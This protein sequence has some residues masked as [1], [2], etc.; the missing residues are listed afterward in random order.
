MDVLVAEKLG[1]RRDEKKRVL[2]LRRENKRKKFREIAYHDKGKKSV[3]GTERVY[4][5]K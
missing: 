3:N 2:L 5:L 1:L 4:T